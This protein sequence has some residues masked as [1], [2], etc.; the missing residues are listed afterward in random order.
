MK[1]Y[2]VFAGYSNFGIGG[3]FNFKGDFDTEDEAGICVGRVFTNLLRPFDWWHIVDTS[4]NKIIK[5]FPK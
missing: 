2:L 1:R 3:W 5:G 4:K